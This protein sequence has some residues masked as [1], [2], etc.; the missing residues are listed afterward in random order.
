MF[1]VLKKKK[2]IIYIAAKQK[3]NKKNGVKT[4][5]NATTHRF[6]HQIV[7]LYCNFCV[8]LLPHCVTVYSFSSVFFL[9]SFL[10][11]NEKFNTTICSPYEND[12]FVCQHVACKCIIFK[13][14]TYML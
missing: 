14:F 6:A 10:R 4:V 2:N 13:L 3:Q 12:I 8:I 9:L 11:D 5:E 7:P 1:I